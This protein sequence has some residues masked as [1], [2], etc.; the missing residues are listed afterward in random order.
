MSDVPCPVETP[1][2]L[3]EGAEEYRKAVELLLVRPTET[4]IEPLGL[5]AA[6]CAELM[7]KA[8][9]LASGESLATLRSQEVRHNLNALWQ[10]ALKRDLP[11]EDPVPFWCEALA[12]AHDKPFMY[13]YP[14]PDW[15]VIVPEPQDLREGLNGL[16][17]AAQMVIAVPGQ[18]VV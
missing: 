7:L 15:G 3:L 14:R 18:D 4:P 12:I 5:L 17:S 6:H 11:L 8:L 10:L 2:S 1:Q 16:F 9:L 13:R